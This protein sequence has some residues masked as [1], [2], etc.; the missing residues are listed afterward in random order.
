MAALRFTNNEGKEFIE[1]TF[2]KNLEEG[3]V[4]LPD[5][6][7]GELVEVPYAKLGISCPVVITE[8][9]IVDVTY[10]PDAIGRRSRV[11]VSMSPSP[12]MG[13]RRGAASEEP[14]GPKMWKLR[15]YDFTIQFYWKP[16][17]R[18][19]RLAPP[20]AAGERTW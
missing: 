10:F 15:R 6:P 7:N 13:G 18:S 9:P 4:E 20:A 12:E 2:F 17:P 19:T 5:G 16:T 1:N 11:G 3:S 8:N 14:V